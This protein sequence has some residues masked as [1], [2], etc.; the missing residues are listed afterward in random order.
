MTVSYLPPSPS[1]LARARWEDIEPFFEELAARQLDSD[2]ITA[3]LHEWSR[4][5]ELVTEAAARAMIAYTI[6]TSDRDKEADHLRFSTEIMPRMEERSVELARK[7][8]A[9]GFRTPELTTTLARFRTQIEIF[10][11]ENV[12]IFAE[13]EEHSA[14]YQRITGSMTAE[15]EGVERPLPQLQPFLKSPDRSVRE[16]AF[17]AASAPYIESRNQLAALFDQM[18]R[19]R[20]QAAHNAGFANFRDYIFPAKFRFDYTPADCEKFHAAIEQTAAPA[21]E[22]V[23]QHRRERLGLDVLRPWDLAVDPYRRNPLRPFSDA[24]DLVGKAK[25]VFDRVHPSLGREFQ[26]MID[27]GLLDLES[28]KGKAPGGYCETLHFHGRP[29]IFMNAVGLVDDVMTLLHEAGHAF[30]AFASHPLPLIWQRHPGSEAAELAS[31]SMEFLA[32]PHLAQPVGYFDT[33]EAR[34]AW[35]EHLEDVLLSLV[36]IASVDAFQTWIYTSGQGGDG[37][38]RDE[39]WLRIRQRF[40]RGV[41]WSGLEQERVAR[42]YRQLHIFMYP[43]YYIEYGIAQIGALQ[44]WRNSLDN[45][46]KAVA[47]Y[48][49]ALALGATRSLPDIYSAAGAR[50]TFD[51]DEIGQLVELVENQIE[52]ARGEL[53]G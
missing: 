38:A 48:R 30:H 9:S 16:Q 17:R 27:E 47:S 49:E 34:S 6:D 42:W 11:E 45:P 5:E 2:N 3:W 1:A 35:L 14:R 31:M 44:V 10:R 19:L 36:H 26:T 40:E 28:R 46:T 25:Q 29:F 43:F 39:A 52:R 12:P 4:L 37:R 7:L 13:L 8:L 50:L 23:L 21:V 33:A 53:P 20:T 18:Y 22:R 32:S 51:V 24:S 41:D 15:W